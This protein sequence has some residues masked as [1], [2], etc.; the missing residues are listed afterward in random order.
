ML[1]TSSVK[2]YP[3]A[4]EDS[5]LKNDEQDKTMWKSVLNLGALATEPECNDCPTLYT[6]VMD[7]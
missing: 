4:V 2:K 6:V 3:W 5:S 1:Q 7:P